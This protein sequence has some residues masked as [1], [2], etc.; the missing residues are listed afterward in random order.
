[1]RPF[2]HPVPDP[3]APG[4]ESVWD[5]PR[6]ARIEAVWVHLRVEFAGRVLAETRNG[7]RAIETSHPP[8]Y[9]F[10][11]ADVDRTLL[12]PASRRTLCEWKGGAAYFDLVAGDRTIADAAWTYPR[13]TPDFSAVAD[14]LAFYPGR[15]DACFVDG[16]PVT[17][18][19]GGF[20]GGW[21][22]SKFGGPFKGPPGTMGW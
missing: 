17:P 3:I 2:G 5:F 19:E 22:T 6:P 4:Q 16:E 7:F 9:Y 20:Y 18:Q 15:V 8:S 14:Y 21:I 13:P 11:P 12:R 1:M 10:P